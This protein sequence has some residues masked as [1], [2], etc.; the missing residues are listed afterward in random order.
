M[1]EL[2]DQSPFGRGR[3]R[4]V[5]HHPDKEDRCLKVMSEDWHECERWQKASWIS[6][7]FRPHRYFHENKREFH[8]SENQQKQVNEHGGEYFARSHR[9]VA[10]DLGDALEVELIIDHDGKISLS[11]KEY[12]LKFGMTPECQKA[13]KEFWEVVEKYGIFL[14][15]RPDN[16]SLRRYADGSCQVVGIDGFGLAQ[17]FPIAKWLASARQSFRKKREKRQQAEIKKILHA[18]ETGQDLGQKGMIR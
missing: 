13:I 4:S 6:R 18:H 15:G 2:K 8:F 1:I 9:F 17:L 10:T 16:V 11:L 12:L 3:H 5:Y 7:T 14:Q